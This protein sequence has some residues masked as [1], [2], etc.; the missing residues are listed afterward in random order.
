MATAPHPA[1]PVD[2]N[3][4]NQALALCF[5]PTSTPQQRSAADRWLQ[6]FQ[7]TPAAWQVA[8]AIL[9]ETAAVDPNVLFFAATTLHAKICNDFGQ[10]A[11][12]S[13]IPLRGAISTHLMRWM[14]TP[15]ASRPVLKRLCLCAAALAVQMTWAEVLHAIPAM[16]EQASPEHRLTVTKM[17]M[18]LLGYLPEECNS[19]W[20]NVEDDKRDAFQAV[21]DGRAAQVLVFVS[22]TSSREDVRTDAECLESILLC[23]MC[24]LRF[25]SIPP[26]VLAEQPLI[27]CALDLLALP[28]VPGPLLEAA[29][30][31]MV[32]L[33]RRYDAS[34]ANAA[35]T[36]LVVPKVM[37]LVPRYM[38]AMQAGPVAEDTCRGL[39][40]V[41]TEM[42][43][44]YMQ[45]I[46]APEQ[47]GVL[48]TQ[49]ILQCTSYPVFGIAKITL[50][51]WYRL[52]KVWHHLEDE[53]TKA[54][55]HATFSPI[56]AALVGQCFR[57]LRCP[58][59]IDD[60][61]RDQRDEFAV[62][63]QQVCDT[64]YDCCVFLGP[65]AVM[66]QLWATVGQE[67]HLLEQ[68]PTRWQGIEACLYALFDDRIEREMVVSECD[69][70]FKN[71]VP[72]LLSLESR[73]VWAAGVRLQY[74]ACQVFGALSGFFRRQGM[75]P[76]L[77]S[78]VFTFLYNHMLRPD[79]TK[80]A[81][82]AIKEICR[83]CPT[84][85]G[86]PVLVVYNQATAANPNM[87]VQNEIILLEAMSYVVRELAP[88]AADRCIRCLLG[89]ISDRLQAGL[90]D[91]STP[92]ARID[93]EL[94][95]L[96]AV[97]KPLELRQPLPPEQP[98]PV[99]AV[100]NETLW[101]ILDQTLQRFS[102][103][104]KIVEKVTRKAAKPPHAPLVRRVLIC[105]CV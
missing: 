22:Q 31:A 83:R 55:L 78:Q 72:L 49:V 6:D 38:E 17:A 86:E 68:A 21:L 76:D 10:L 63:R 101:R 61:S 18:E 48:V 99:A 27:P 16:I 70:Y 104:E 32:E 15:G 29:V 81:A 85:L 42:G 91:P 98:H 25:C 75:E 33:F 84:E 71:M 69:P 52:V 7:R 11:P 73:P 9:A 97:V 19:L 62:Q 2:M 40:R 88:D 57:L 47:N 64:L 80:A 94:L 23:L 36:Q 12:E 82:V 43:E 37:A 46:L 87:G 105:V 54:Q 100:L 30:D 24:W 89:P 79:T 53:A 51:F 26:A 39:V 5:G 56:M 20:V 4:L 74:S 60:Y 45:L 93:H 3:E 77:L 13:Q 66:E 41:F 8:E 96:F 95:R 92:E 28:Q 1:P 103:N 14:L 65:A 34:P 35:L 44:S 50:F 90:M 59:D 58:D 67:F 102:T